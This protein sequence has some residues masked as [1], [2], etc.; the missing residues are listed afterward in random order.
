MVGKRTIS[1]REELGILT[2]SIPS[3][4]LRNIANQTFSYH[5][6][7][8]IGMALIPDVIVTIV[9]LVLILNPMHHSTYSLHPVFALV[10]SIV[11]M[12]MYANV[13]WLNVFIARSN[14]VGFHRSEVWEKLVYAETAFEGVICLLWI[15]MLVYSCVAVDKWRRAKKVGSAEGDRSVEGV[16][17]DGR[18]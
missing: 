8:R 9:Y 5:F 4:N 10:S 1:V 11:M 6:W 3:P 15:A 2:V 12:A 7:L 16:P 14:E 18:V 17:A 13:T